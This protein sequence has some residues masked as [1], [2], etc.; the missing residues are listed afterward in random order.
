M[1]LSKDEIYHNWKFCALY[2]MMVLFPEESPFYSLLS[3]T[4]SIT[5]LVQN[6]ISFLWYGT[7][8]SFEAVQKEKAKVTVDTCIEYLFDTCKMWF[9]QN[10]KTVPK[11]Y[12]KDLG[13][14]LKEKKRYFI[15]SIDPIYIYEET[16]PEPS[17]VVPATPNEGKSNDIRIVLKSTYK[18]QN[19]DYSS[20]LLLRTSEPKDFQ[21]VIDDYLSLYSHVYS[22][23]SEQEVDYSTLLISIV[24]PIT[25]WASSDLLIFRSH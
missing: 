5:Q 13:Y 18:P 7:Q 2:Q 6:K 21:I 20:F 17:T 3:L 11:V 4:D 1:S 8:L 12:T 16:L 9:T 10:E 23:D 14:D 19:T 25:I 22:W 15:L 24:L